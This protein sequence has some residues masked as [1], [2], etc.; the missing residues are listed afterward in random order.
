MSQLGTGSFKRDGWIYSHIISGDRLCVS[1]FRLT[2]EGRQDSRLDSRI[3]NE[4]PSWWQEK[5]DDL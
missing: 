2:Y 4:E 3:L 5:N 1:P